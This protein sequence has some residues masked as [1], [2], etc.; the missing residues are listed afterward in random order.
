MK[1]E[2]V[3]DTLDYGKGSAKRGNYYFHVTTLS[4]GNYNAKGKKV[5]EEN[6]TMNY[7]FTY[8]GETLLVIQQ[9]KK[10]K[11]NYEHVIMYDGR[12]KHDFNKNINKTLDRIIS[13]MIEPYSVYKEKY[14]R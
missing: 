13:Y 14:E 12:E 3:F 6:K 11:Y 10:S 4:N 1:L 7:Y 2:Q 8:K 5:T 9:I